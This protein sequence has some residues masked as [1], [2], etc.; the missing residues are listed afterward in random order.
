MITYGDLFDAL[1][2]TGLPVAYH[3]F[4]KSPSLPYLVFLRDGADSVGADDKN[5]VKLNSWIVELYT[6]QKDI[7]RETRIE[8]ILD[9]LGAVY[10]TTEGYLDTEKMYL[11]RYEFGG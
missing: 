8:A 7:E 1:I 3:H 6:E 4:T 10:T 5:F 11:V 9:A 2:L